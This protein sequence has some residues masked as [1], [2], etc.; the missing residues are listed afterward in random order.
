MS[1]QQMILVTGTS[2]GFGR[3]TV[4]TLA[5]QGYRVFA[6]MRNTQG[7]NAGH[8]QE[9]RA[10]AEREHLAIHV[11]DLD[12]SDETSVNRA[13]TTVVE[14]AGRIDVL[15]NNVGIGAWGIA[16]GYTL[17]QVKELFETNVFSVVRMNR[18]VLPTMRKQQS[19]LLLHIS[20][21]VGRFVLPF[22]VNYSAAKHAVEALAEGYHY[23]LAPLGIDSVIVEPG[24]YPT[25]GSIQK[26][27]GP[28]EEDRV[29]GYGSLPERAQHLYDGNAQTYSTSAAPDAQEVANVIAK[30]IQTSAGQRPLRTTVG[31][32]P[33]PM[34]D[35]I[36]EL[37]DQI[38]SQTLQYMGLGDLVNVASHT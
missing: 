14:T 15:I 19:G 11:V 30:L 34:I 21:A 31:G 6:A 17:D 35:P 23:E 20:A 22:M 18:A 1:S 25:V 9:V 36:N 37:T 33:A 3:L 8:A 13:V 4:E 2:S 29:V 5:R 28:K 16:E 38:Q 32:P 26:L 27:M 10:L 7:R 12:T 24:A